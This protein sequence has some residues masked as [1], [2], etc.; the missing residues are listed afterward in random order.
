MSIEF[1]SPAARV[2]KQFSGKDEEQFRIPVDLPDITFL[3]AL[4]VQGRLRFFQTSDLNANPITITPPTGET[5]FFYRAEFSQTAAASGDVTISND[6]NTRWSMELTQVSIGQGQLITEFIDSLVG[7]GTKT[8]NIT[9]D[10]ATSVVHTS[11]F[12]WV[13]NTSRIRDATI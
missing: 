3:R 5:F 13:E 11:I 4:S 6:G 10:T 2:I 1:E 7:D 8:F 12:G 9:D